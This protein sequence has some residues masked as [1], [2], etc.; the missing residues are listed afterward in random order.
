[1]KFNVG[2]RVRVRKDSKFM[3][4]EYAGKEGKICEANKGDSYPYRIKGL[5]SVWHANELELVRKK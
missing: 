3:K 5:N 2:D 4:G 1:M